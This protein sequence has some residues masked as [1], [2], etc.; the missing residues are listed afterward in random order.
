MNHSSSLPIYDKMARHPRNKARK[1][2]GN[3]NKNLGLSAQAGRSV[4]QRPKAKDKRLEDLVQ[5][6]QKELEEQKEKTEAVERRNEAFRKEVRR[7]KQEL[8]KAV[9]PGKSGAANRFRA[10]PKNS[11]GFPCSQKQRELDRITQPPPF[12]PH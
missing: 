11:F 2:S 8:K 4:D 6:L 9:K 12:N 1:S 3:K 10:A 7:V 5:Q